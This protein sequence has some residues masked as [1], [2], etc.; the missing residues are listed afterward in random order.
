MLTSINF[1]SVYIFEVNIYNI[2]MYVCRPKLTLKKK[3]KN[4]YT[5]IYLFVC[6]FIFIHI[7][8]F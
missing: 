6:L 3:K 5:T 7:F 8:F 4:N 1:H 2:F